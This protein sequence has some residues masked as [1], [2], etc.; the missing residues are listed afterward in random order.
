M[1]PYAPH[2]DTIIVGRDAE[3]AVQRP[4]DL[5]SVILKFVNI[6]G[7]T[8]YVRNVALHCT[9]KLTPEEATYIPESEYGAVF[10]RAR[11]YALIYIGVF[12]LAIYT[13][14][15]REKDGKILFPVTSAHGVGLA[16]TTTTYTF[17][18]VSNDHVATFIKELVLE[19]D[20]SS[21]ALVY[22]PGDYLQFD[23][24]PYQTYGPG[25]GLPGRRCRDG[26]APVAPVA[27]A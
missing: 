8:T 9:G 7:I 24:P 11:I 15:V 20:P 10:L 26:P 5:W 12:A 25:N 13:Y 1:E 17:R 27:P 23:I 2:S 14:D 18:V 3:I 22:Q 16:E 19:A 4:V 6:K 21:P